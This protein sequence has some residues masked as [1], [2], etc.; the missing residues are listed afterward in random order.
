MA[1]KQ[2]NID[3]VRYTSYDNVKEVTDFIL[4]SDVEVDTEVLHRSPKL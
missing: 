3:F 2:T 1:K 4:K